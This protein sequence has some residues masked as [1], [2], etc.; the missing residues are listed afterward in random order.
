[1][2][3]WARLSNMQYQKLQYEKNQEFNF[4]NKYLHSLRY[5]NLISVVSEFESKVSERPIKILEIGS[6]IGK[7]FQLLD[8]RFNIEYWGIELLEKFHQVA[9]RRYG[10]KEN[11]HNILGSAFDKSIFNMPKPDIVIALETFEHM[12]ERHLV[13]L[14]EFLS[15]VIKPTILICSVP[16]EIGP[17]L[18]IKNIGSFIIGYTRHN[19]YS[20]K[21]TFWAGFYQL[22]KLPPHGTGEGYAGHK[23]FDHRWLAQTIRQNF[24]ILEIRNFPIAFL[25]AALATS[26]FMVAIPR[27]WKKV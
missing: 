19:Q 26:V 2:R 15:D 14:I 5:K 7:S 23:G 21:E 10:Q 6:G 1:M 22:D 12:P 4:I 24:K 13:R 11:F 27:K 9:D 25:P 3:F 16:V 18:W 17:I 8:A 20:W